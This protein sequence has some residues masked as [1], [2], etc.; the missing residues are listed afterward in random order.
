MSGNRSYMERATPVPSGSM[1]LILTQPAKKNSWM[2]KGRLS[3]GSDPYA[4]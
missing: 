1:L 4:A 3:L 2:S